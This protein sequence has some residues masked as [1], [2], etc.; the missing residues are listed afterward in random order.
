M[1]SWQI[2]MNNWVLPS[3]TMPWLCIWEHY[4]FV[5]WPDSHRLWKHMSLMGLFACQTWSLISI[6]CPFNIQYIRTKFIKCQFHI[7]R[8]RKNK[9]SQQ[10]IKAVKRVTVNK[11]TRVNKWRW[12]KLTMVR[13]LSFKNVF[14]VMKNPKSDMLSENKNQ[15]LDNH[16]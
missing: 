5:Q 6:L 4:V 16:E 15:Q 3:M 14:N 9:Q 8:T 10:R 7:T 2:W 13:H 11:E 1:A 12:L